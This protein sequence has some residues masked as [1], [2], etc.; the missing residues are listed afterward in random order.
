MEQEK[1]INGTLLGSTFIILILIA[2]GIYTWQSKARMLI[3]E[4]EA[5]EASI[6]ANQHEL[7]SLENDLSANAS[8]SI[9]YSQ[10]Q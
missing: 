7:D 8:G 10:A 3:K 9:D 4:K 5:Q 2:G 6:E 1:K